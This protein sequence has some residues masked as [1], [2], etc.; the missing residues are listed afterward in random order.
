MINEAVILA[1]GFGTRL[2]SLVKEVPKS[3]AL[4]NGK[5]FLEFQLNYLLKFGINKIV[6]SVG[7]KNEF[8]QSYFGS[9]FKTIAISYAIENEP[10]G[11]GGG[12][13][14]ALKNIEGN[15]AY[16]LNGDTMFEVDLLEYYNFHKKKDSKLS[17]SLR[18]L[19]DVSRFGSVETDSENRITGFYEKNFVKSSGY[20][21]GG[22]Y[23]INRCF[24]E[25]LNLGTK[26]SIEHDCFEKIYKTEKLFGFRCD[27]YFLD[28]GIPDD[29]NKAQYEF[30]RFENKLPQI[31]NAKSKRNS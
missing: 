6:F 5:P 24:Y 9:R 26:F 11:T 30:R 25:N 27:D 10:L 13:K 4:I 15:E 22:I 14:N 18:F 12:I 3:M 17:L 29:F 2:K 8:I 20:I 19:E 16:V 21:N 7:Y 31:Q 23:I 1:G 28:I